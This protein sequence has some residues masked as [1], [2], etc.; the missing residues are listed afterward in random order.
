MFLS[1]HSLKCMTPWTVHAKK[2]EHA[3]AKTQNGY[4]TDVTWLVRMQ[5]G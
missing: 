4:E 5:R 1:V 3:S 2:H